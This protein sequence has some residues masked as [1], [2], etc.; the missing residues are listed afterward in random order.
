MRVKLFLAVFVVFHGVE[1][2]DKFIE[3]RKEFGIHTLAAPQTN[4]IQLAKCLHK[5]QKNVKNN[6]QLTECL[7]FTNAV[8]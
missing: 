4:L 3:N 2:I 5:F 7:F 1:T 6:S 8:A